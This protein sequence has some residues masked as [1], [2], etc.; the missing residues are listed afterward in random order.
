MGALSGA[1]LGPAL[2]QPV[3]PGPQ[4]VA[5]GMPLFERRPTPALADVQALRFVDWHPQRPEML[6]LARGGGATQLHRLRAAGA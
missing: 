3:R 6:V 4:L 5:D 2:A 1:L